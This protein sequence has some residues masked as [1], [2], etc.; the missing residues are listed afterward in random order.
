MAFEAVRQIVEIRLFA[1]KFYTITS[2]DLAETFKNDGTSN[3]DTGTVFNNEIFNGANAQFPGLGLT[4]DKL[5]ALNGGQ[6]NLNSK[7]FLG[8]RILVQASTEVTSFPIYLEGRP[9]NSAVTDSTDGKWAVLT[10]DDGASVGRAFGAVRTDTGTTR[11]KLV[12]TSLDS[13]TVRLKLF[14]PFGTGTKIIRDMA[15]ELDDYL[16]YS[17]GDSGTGNGGTLFMK[18]GNLTRI[19]SEDDGRLTYNLDYI[20]DYYYTST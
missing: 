13:G 6:G 4:N 20:Y 8:S 3:N 2:A 10:I 14:A 9:T 11:P 17:G 12:R 1:S 15:D 7:K 5:I 18:D 16:A 19:S